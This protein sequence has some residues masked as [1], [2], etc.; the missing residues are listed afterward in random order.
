M[1][2]PRKHEKNMELISIHKP[3]QHQLRKNKYNR[4]C[5]LQCQNKSQFR[6]KNKKAS[7]KNNCP[8]NN[9]KIPRH[10]HNNVHHLSSNKSSSLHKKSSPTV[11]LH[12]ARNV[13]KSEQNI[14]KGY[15]L[16]QSNSLL[17]FWMLIYN[18]HQSAI[19]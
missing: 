4:K 16:T 14:I 1:E 17:L 6:N 7:R 5:L 2:I 13:I 18:V 11:A 15:A 19:R 10:P 12:F 3:N 8:N 9:I